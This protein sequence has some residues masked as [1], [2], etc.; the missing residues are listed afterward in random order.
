MPTKSVGTYAPP[1]E[2]APQ[3]NAMRETAQRLKLHFGE[4]NIVPAQRPA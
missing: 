4:Y 1:A 3:M 2:I